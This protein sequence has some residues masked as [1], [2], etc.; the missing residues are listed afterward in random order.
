MRA[1]FGCALVLAAGC[2]G[3]L[4]DP[5]RFTAA[6][7]DVPTQ[8][9]ATSC[10]TNGC[11]DAATRAAS[12]DLITPDVGAR[13]LNRSAVGGPGLLID[14]ANPDG[15]VLVRKLTPTPPFGA[16]QP[17]GAPLDPASIDC[18]RRWVRSVVVTDGGT[19]D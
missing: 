5:A 3:S 17:P 19:S 13:L 11:H 10:A 4:Q 15:S 7:P 8:I 16:Q 14:A 18:I 12:L 6:C 2:P 1:L 9:L